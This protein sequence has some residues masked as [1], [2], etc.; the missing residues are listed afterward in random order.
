MI[1]GAFAMSNDIPPF[2]MAAGR[3]LRG[4]NSVRLLRS[5]VESAV[6]SE[7]RELFRLVRAAAPNVRAA[8]DQLR[9]LATT[10]VSQQL[11]AFL[12]EPSRR[13]YSRIASA[14]RD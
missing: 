11:V 2:C 12:E 10:E 8:L 7:L 5:G 6:M 14:R 3:Y 9:E 1:G 4:L 13:G